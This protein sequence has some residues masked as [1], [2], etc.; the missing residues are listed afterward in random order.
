M[1]HPQPSNDTGAMSAGLVPAGIEITEANLEAEVLVRSARSPVVV[2]I[3]SPHSETSVQLGI[4]LATLADEDG[5]KWSFATVNLA[6]DRRAARM[7]GVQGVPT[8]VAVVAGEP[9]STFAGPRQPNQ[10]R[11]WIDSL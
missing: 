1:N 3:W 2:L 4:L 7:F 11:K 8:V 6:K 9:V 5:G 10:L